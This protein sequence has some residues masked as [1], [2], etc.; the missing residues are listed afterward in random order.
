[1]LEPGDLVMA[2]KGFDIEDLLREKGVELN[3]P[4]FLESLEQFSAQDVQKTK[5]I[6][7]LRIHVERAIRRVKGYHSFGSDVPLSALCSVNQSCIDYSLTNFQG[8]LILSNSNN[9]P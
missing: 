4:S 7:S 8:P 2:D 5:R 3:I 9:E 6:A 1:M